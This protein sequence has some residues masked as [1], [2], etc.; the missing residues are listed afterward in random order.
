MNHQTEKAIERLVVEINSASAEIANWQTQLDEAKIELMSLLEKHELDTIDVEVREEET[1]ITIVRPSQLKIDE[2]GL[3]DAVSEAIWR[4]IT[5][6]VIDKKALEDAVAKGK[7]EAVTVSKHSKE[8]ATKPYL[9]I[10]K[11]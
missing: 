8:V 1:K 7:V 11:R 4:S 10:T 5:K 3:E 6:R 2:E 9:R